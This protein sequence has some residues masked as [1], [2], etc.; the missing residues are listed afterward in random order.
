MV[1]TRTGQNCVT[2]D[3]IAVSLQGLKANVPVDSYS[4]N[5]T[6]RR[7]YSGNPGPDVFEQP[8]TIT[9]STPTK[10]GDIYFF[11]GSASGTQDPKFYNPAFP[12]RPFD[13]NSNP[14]Q[15]KV[16][17]VKWGAAAP[18]GIIV[19]PT[20][21]LPPNTPPNINLNTGYNGVPDY[22]E[23]KGDFKNLLKVES[24]PELIAAIIRILLVLIASI[25][26]I[27]IIISGFRMVMYGSNP[28]ELSKAKAAIVWSVLGLVIALM[29]FSIVSIIQGIIQR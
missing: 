11:Q 2:D 1:V 17:I 29:A 25:A 10:N 24:I 14:S 13:I 19:T 5:K 26:V 28:A 16:C 9:L 3:Y 20:P 12:A 15:V 7:R 18:T 21:T 6:I 4:F 22:D 27:V 8:F 23:V